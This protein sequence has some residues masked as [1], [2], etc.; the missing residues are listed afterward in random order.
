[1]DGENKGKPENPIKM[2]DLGGFPIIFGN[3]YISG[4]CSCQLGNFFCHLLPTF[5]GNQKQPLIGGSSH[6]V[7][8]SIWQYDDRCLGVSFKD[9]VVK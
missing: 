9:A 7:S 3:T 1:M 8:G 4:I 5:S 2:D 6:L